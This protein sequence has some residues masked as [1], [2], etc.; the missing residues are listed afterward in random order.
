VAV[1]VDMLAFVRQSQRVVLHRVTGEFN[2]DYQ[3]YK[4]NP[5]VGGYIEISQTSLSRAD[6]TK[7]AEILGTSANYLAVDE[8]W[9]CL[10][11]PIY[12]IEASGREESVN[13]VVDACG[14]IEMQELTASHQKRIWQH[15]LRPSQAERQLWSILHNR[16]HSD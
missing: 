7:V 13:I 16:I 4:R 8:T 15:G 12:R 1:P 10:P 3:R 14:D 5:L 9:T 6:V 2:D 11:Q